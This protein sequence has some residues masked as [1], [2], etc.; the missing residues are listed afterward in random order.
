MPKNIRLFIAFRLLFNARFYYP[1]FAVIQLDYGLTM[2]Q[3]ALLNAV[4]AVTI[5]VLEV[6]SG[7]LADRIGRKQM[8]VWASILMVLE[9]AVIAF[10]PF[11][12]PSIVFIA[13]V[14]NRILSGAAEAAA[15]GADEALAYDS[16]P[17][18]KQESEWPGVLARLMKLSSLAFVSAMIIG[19]A[20]YDPIF[21]SKL[22]NG[23][24][25][26]IAIT[27]MQA[28]RFPVYLTLLSSIFAVYVA[29]AM[30]EP[31][32]ETKCSG[33]CSLW[34][35]VFSA[36]KW[37][38]KTPIVFAIILAALIHDSLVRL[39]LT[40]GSEYYRLIQIPEVAFGLIGAAFSGLGII[41]SGMAKNL[42]ERY[43]I[44]KNFLIVSILVLIGLFGITLAIPIYG[45]LVIIFLSAAFS[46]LNF[47]TSHYLNAEVDSHHRATVLSFRG[48]A[49]NLGFGSLSLLYAALLKGLR[50]PG[51]TD[52]LVHAS[53]SIFRE[54][55]Y[56]LPG[57]FMVMLVPLLVYYFIYVRKYRR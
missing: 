19:A 18:D 55:L 38:L 33:P 43:S 46:F 53:S 5:V 3:F 54:S 9:I 41:T 34:S 28:I 42:V 23:L 21:I 22:C 57:T 7:A 25:L 56:W 14:I 48:L 44:E 45:V 8:V 16:L 4:W 11:G 10:V 24:G 49:L 29:L 2:E 39:F 26:D 35:G 50:D 40:A 51:N 31:P 12:N 6:P 32:Q 52:P 17:A 37:I 20:V 13:W 47:F 27:K 15:S 30:T 36:G 1:V